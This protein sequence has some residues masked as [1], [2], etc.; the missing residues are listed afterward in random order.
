MKSEYQIQKPKTERLYNE[1]AAPAPS[2]FLRIH[3]LGLVNS[4][5]GTSVL[6]LDP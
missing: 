1:Y 2:H 6:L 4:L 5:K 3:S